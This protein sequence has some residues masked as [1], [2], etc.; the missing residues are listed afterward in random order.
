M[1][2]LLL[3][4]GALLGPASAQRVVCDPTNVNIYQ[5]DSM[6]I[7]GNETITFDRYAGKVSTTIII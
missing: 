7:Y 1:L 6:S 2:R 5:F 4:A 3:L